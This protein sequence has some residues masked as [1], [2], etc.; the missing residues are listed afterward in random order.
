VSSPLPG[1]AWCITR[2]ARSAASR[3][4]TAPVRAKSQLNSPRYTG[5]RVNGQEPGPSASAEQGT[6][7]A[8][9]KSIAEMAA[10]PA[11]DGSHGGAFAARLRAHARGLRTGCC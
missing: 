9:A 7:L 2:S 3:R 8:P 4:A 10:V 11:S 5:V 1:H 6:V